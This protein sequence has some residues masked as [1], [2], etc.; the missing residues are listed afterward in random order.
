MERVVVRVYDR[1][2]KYALTRK[3]YFAVLE[4]EVNL[5]MLEDYQNYMEYLYRRLAQISG[6]KWQRYTSYVIGIVS[7]LKE[8]ELFF[9]E[10]CHNEIYEAKIDVSRVKEMEKYKLPIEMTYYPDFDN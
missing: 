3:C 6:M 1:D 5:E 10:V 4:K 2:D 7:D 8:D 9:C